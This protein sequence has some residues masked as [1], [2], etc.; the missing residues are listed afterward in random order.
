M[1]F[2]RPFDKSHQALRM[3]RM[4]MAQYNSAEFLGSYL[5][6]IQIVHE[7]VLA[8]P[9]IEEQGFRRVITPHGHHRGKPMFG[10][11]DLASDGIRMQRESLGLRRASHQHID[12]VVQYGQDLNSV[13]LSEWHCGHVYASFP[14][15]Y[16]KWLRRFNSPVHNVQPALVSA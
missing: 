16:M 14:W 12:G 1:R 10:N 8:Q 2:P 11:K 6:Y 5:Q 15:S 4:A 13:C 3:V 7:P 9:C